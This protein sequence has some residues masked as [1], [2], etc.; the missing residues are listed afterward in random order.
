MVLYDEGFISGSPDR[1]WSVLEDVEL[2]PLWNHKCVACDARGTKAYNGLRF[3]A[4]FKMSGPASRASCEVVALDPRIRI[5]FRYI[6]ESTHKG[7]HVDETFH[8]DALENGKQVRLRHELCISNAPIPFWLKCLAWIMS[9]IGEKRG[10]SSIDG[11]RN[12][13]EGAPDSLPSILT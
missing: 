5:T 10:L 4:T 7:R 13:V 3:S 6:L 1:V 2:M 8:L 11:I 9:R 12:L